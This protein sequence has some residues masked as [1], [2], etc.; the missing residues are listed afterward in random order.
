[1]HGLLRNI[2]Q[3]II[4]L[5]KALSE[6]KINLKSDSRKKKPCK[7]ILDMIDARRASTKRHVGSVSIPL[8]FPTTTTNSAFLSFRSLRPG[9]VT[10]S[11]FTP[12]REVGPP[13]SAAGS[14]L[15]TKGGPVLWE[16]QQG[17]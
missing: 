2:S 16:A 9:T 3:R 6:G 7:D 17:E 10:A 15:H 12:P 1:L 11:P 5:E 13:F 14:G 4:Y 8:L